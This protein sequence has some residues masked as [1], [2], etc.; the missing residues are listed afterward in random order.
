M[1]PTDLELARERFLRD[2]AILNFYYDTPIIT[3]I[4]L[5]LRTRCLVH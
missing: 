3:A 5:E 1:Y 4:T 2:I